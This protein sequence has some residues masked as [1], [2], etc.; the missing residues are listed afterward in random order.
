MQENDAWYQKR[1]PGLDTSPTLTQDHLGNGVQWL[2]TYC[3]A[4]IV[5]VNVQRFDDHENQNI[6]S[7]ERPGI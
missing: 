3:I 4:C 6:L 7:G 2:L 1:P 5:S